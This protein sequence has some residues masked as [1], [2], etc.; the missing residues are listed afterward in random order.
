[1]PSSLDLTLAFTL[2]PDRAI[3][4]FRSRDL[5]IAGDWQQVAHAVRNGSFS[6]AGVMKAQVLGDIQTALERALAS[7]TTYADFLR[8]LKPKLAAAGWLGRFPADPATGEIVSGKGLTPRHLDT[9]FRTNLQSAY[10]AGRLKG[11]VEASDSHPYWQY[12]AILDNRTRPGHR[13]LNGRVFRWDDP[14]WKVI[15]PPNGYKCRCRVRPLSQADMDRESL[16]LSN[17]GDH[18][19]TVI[20]DLGPRGGKMS[21]T[22]YRDPATGDRMMPDP[23]FDH[24]P[25]D[26]WRVEVELARRVAAIGNRD[27]RVQAWQ[28]LNNSPARIAP[29]ADRVEEIVG[30][31]GMD[32]RP[33]AG[34][35]AFVLGFVDEPVAD[36]VRRMAPEADPT[37]VL[38]MPDKRLWHADSPKHLAEGVAL[39]RDQYLML[40]GMVARPDA[41]YWDREHGNLTYVRQLVDG[42]AVIMPVSPGWQAKKVGAIDAAVN[43]MRLLPGPDGAGRLSNTGRFVRMGSES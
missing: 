32:P 43:A 41:V 26:A 4:Y 34:P 11:M 38:V 33:G 21:V 5:R 1:M 27:V 31:R 14:I 30:T 36:F 2:P 25:A 9:V 22:G 42:S 8:E 29:W 28:A 18:M 7:G 23:G 12:V 39:D 6:V 13:A 3:E 20:A 24:S 35:D 15:Y 16:A 17:G 19:E 37:R 40:P 10:M